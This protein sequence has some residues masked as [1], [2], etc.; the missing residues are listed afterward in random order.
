[1]ITASH[2]PIDDNG[3]K[4]IDSDGGMLDQ[5]WET[6][7]N[8]IVNAS[9]YDDIIIT[10]DKLV[11]DMDIK[12]SDTSST[13][14][15][16]V[17]IAYDTRPHSKHLADL[18]ENAAKSIGCDVKSFGL[19]TTPQ[20]HH[21][22]RFINDPEEFND[23]LSTE[24][25][26]YERLLT[27]FKT[28]VQ[29]PS[30]T[31]EQSTSTATTAATVDG[32]KVIPVIV[33]CANGVGGAKI[34][35]L[36]KHPSLD[37]KESNGDGYYTLPGCNI[38]LTLRNISDLSKLNHKVGAE[39]VQKMQQL[40]EN[41]IDIEKEKNILCCSFDGDADRIVFY[42]L[43]DQSNMHLLDGDKIASLFA[44]FIKN[45]LSILGDEANA[46]KVGVVQTAY[47]NG[48]SRAFLHSLGMETALV[49][50]GVKY[51]HGKAH[52]YDVGV[53]FEANGHGTVLF[54]KKF[55]REIG[56][57]QYETPEKQQA[58]IRLVSFAN[59]INQATGDAISD[60]LA[61]LGVLIA[62]NITKEQWDKL[63]ADFPSRQLKVKVKDRSLITTTD[64]ETRTLAPEGLQD[65]ID[66][67]VKQYPN[68]RAFV[69]PSGTE[70]VVRIYAEA[71]SD[72]SD[73]DLL[74]YQVSQSAYDL[75]NGVGDRP[76]I[77]DELQEA[78]KTK[79]MKN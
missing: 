33:D 60:L 75:C 61:V 52:E 55:V 72:A 40:P 57:V 46:F 15:G 48:A 70:D 9:S 6:Y 69:R 2:N 5:A 77:P 1:M 45:Q 34:L 28:L 79:R 68:G 29:Y 41:T 11:N 16:K 73:A 4:L 38:K 67:L 64:D 36:L 76:V 7:A 24:N 32:S 42:Y 3:V 54:S 66:A 21:I 8:N 56:K 22:V 13:G 19:L 44:M 51:L 35:E 53:Y 30:G 31:T 62:S 50:T 23:D 17:L 71:N 43:D 74:A 37:Q 47:A 25:G 58:Q 12:S 65:A 20:L 78:S 10:I 39:H 49:K 18:A 14:N 59:L 27:S 63:Y 26:Y